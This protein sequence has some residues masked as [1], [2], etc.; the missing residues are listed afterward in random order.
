[1]IILITCVVLSKLFLNVRYEGHDTIFHVSNIVKLSET[2]SLDNIFGSNL[3][4]SDINKFGYGVWLFY[5]KFPHL[6]ASYLYLLIDNIYLSMNIIYF[7]TTVLSGIF[8]YFLSKK[9]FNNRN[10]A[11]LSSIIYIMMPYHISDIYMR[12]AFAEN[13]MFMILPMILLGLYNLKDNNYISFYLLFNLGYLIGV[14][15]HLCCMF[16]YTIFIAIFIIYYRDVF[17]KKDRF[18]HLLCSTLIVTSISL[19]FLVTLLEHK[20]LGIYRVFG[21]AFSNINY[22]QTFTMTLG[23]F[24]QR[25]TDVMLYLNIFVVILFVITSVDL[26]IN[27]KSS[28][29]KDKKIMLILILVIFVFLCSKAIWEYLPDIFLSI[30]FPWRLLIMFSLLISLY[31]PLCLMNKKIPKY[32]GKIILVFVAYAVIVD[33]FFNINYF[34]DREIPIEDA[35]IHD[36]SLGYAREYFPK[37][38]VDIMNTLMYGVEF[39]KNK[40]YKISADNDIVVEIIEDNFP[41]MEFVVDDLSADTVIELPRIFYLGYELKDEDGNIIKLNNNNFGFIEANINKE[42][43]YSLNYVKTDLHKLA[44]YIKWITIFIIFLVLVV[45]GFKWTKKR[46]QY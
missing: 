27:K 19:P 17:F 32:V 10:I 18:K 4:T 3:I 44:I 37:V 34:G 25:D 26:F 7:I 2:I 33:G 30:Q 16:F 28:Y 36:Y 23:S 29:R 12:D 1:M 39:Y 15:S 13:F 14:N 42:G 41:N 5:P 8:T 46:L 45:K 11:L 22:V 38:E 24:F 9:I 43:K 31:V 21:Y 20:A 6:V 35:I 40:E